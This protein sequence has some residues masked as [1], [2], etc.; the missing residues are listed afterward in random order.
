[1]PVKVWR[2]K[3]CGDPYIGEEA[4]KNCPFCGAHQKNIVLAKTW[5]WP[6]DVQLTDISRN[7]L[8]KALEIE[9]SNAQFYFCAANMVKDNEGKQ[10]FKALGKVEKEH[11]SLIAKT[12]GMAKPEVEETPGV[13]S[14][15]YQEDL[16]ESHAREER[17]IKHYSQFLSEAT[18]DRVKEI[19]AA[20]VEI[21]KD[22]LGLSKERMK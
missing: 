8:M 17:A 11:A 4:P 10:M 12:L 21:E 22:H 16:K 3:I 1:M 14:P 19:F 9:V 7:N 18:E 13:C 15:E 20:L 2:C 6:K 5:D